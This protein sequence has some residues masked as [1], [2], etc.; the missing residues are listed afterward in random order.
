MG[1]YITNQQGGA[2]TQ[3]GLRANTRQRPVAWLRR[4]HSVYTAF[5]ITRCK[6]AL[7]L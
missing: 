4:I 3:S 6:Q 5:V 7:D 1:T 2:V